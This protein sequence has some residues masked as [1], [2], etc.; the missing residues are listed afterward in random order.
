MINRQL[1]LPAIKL[2]LVEP[3][4]RLTWWL[5]ET[6]NTSHH[7]LKNWFNLLLIAVFVRVSGL[8]LLLLLFIT[9]GKLLLGLAFS[10][11]D[12]RLFSNDLLGP[13]LPSLL[14]SL[15]P[16]D[17]FGCFFPTPH[18]GQA[19]HLFLEV[20]VVVWGVRFSALLFFGRPFVCRR[21]LAALFWIRGDHIQFTLRL[22]F[23]S[24]AGGYLLLLG[25]FPEAFSGSFSSELAFEAAVCRTSGTSSESE[26][27]CG[28]TASL[29]SCFAAVDL[30]LR[31]RLLFASGDCRSGC[32]LHPGGASAIL[33]LFWQRVPIHVFWRRLFFALISFYGDFK[34][35]GC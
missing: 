3:F 29:R 13:F 33:T 24:R 31:L 32:G 17:T 26:S 34:R 20:R 9:G 2:I 25:T 21:W 11:C 15:S 6:I 12:L 27:H 30:S 16:F 5:M 19:F 23:L 18:L 35:N 7:G 28:F 8:L 22:R 4:F 1:I 14:D 10:L